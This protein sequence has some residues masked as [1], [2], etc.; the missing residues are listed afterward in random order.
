M[1]VARKKGKCER[2]PE[3]KTRLAVPRMAGVEWLQE[4]CQDKRLGRSPMPKSPGE[5][6]ADSCLCVKTQ[7][8]L[9][10]LKPGVTR[11]VLFLLEV[12]GPGTLWQELRIRSSLLFPARKH[13]DRQEAETGFHPKH[14]RKRCRHTRG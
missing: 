13:E 9:Y 1:G 12:P 6:G 4:R 3:A 14:S 11:L 2:S 10:S 8:S 7:K 5:R